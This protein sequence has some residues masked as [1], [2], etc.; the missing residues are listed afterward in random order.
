LLPVRA[1]CVGRPAVGG[2]TESDVSGWTVDTLRQHF[3]RQHDDLKDLLGERADSQ[4][5]AMSAALASAEKAVTVANTAAEK[6]FDSVNE[7]RQTL[8][9]QANTLMSRAEATALLAAL[10][11]RLTRLEDRMNTATGQDTG[12]REAEAL[13]RAGTQQAVAVIGAVIAIV[14]IA[15]ALILGLNT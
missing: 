8:T 9:D 2:E 15:V 10:S 14:S 12:N 13:R 3:Q 1:P 6:R 5:V 4:R 11:E 7:F